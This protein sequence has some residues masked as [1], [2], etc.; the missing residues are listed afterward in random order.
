MELQNCATFAVF[1]SKD[2]EKIFR[3]SEESSDHDLKNPTISLNLYS[4][5]LLEVM[6]GGKKEIKIER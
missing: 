3:R 2:S 1:S 6:R 5:L 4:F